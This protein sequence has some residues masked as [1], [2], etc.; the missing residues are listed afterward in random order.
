MAEGLT[1]CFA[2][3]VK[4]GRLT[5]SNRVLSKDAWELQLL[6][7]GR[8]RQHQ[9]R[10]RSRRQVSRCPAAQLRMPRHLKLYVEIERTP[11]FM[12]APG[13]RKVQMEQLFCKMSY[14]T[15]RGSGEDGDDN[16]VGNAFEKGLMGML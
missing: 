6:C 3:E 10:P 14:N 5:A 2:S 11:T 4:P 9:Q 16:L 15:C 13:G 8:E 7:F 1:S 12:W